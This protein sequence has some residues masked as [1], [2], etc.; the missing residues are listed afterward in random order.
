[1]NEK[2]PV[3]RPLITLDDLPKGWDKKLITMGKEGKF[4][5]HVRTYLNI[6][7]DTFYRL[8][9]DEPKFLET[10]NR[11]RELSQEWWVN[12]P[13]ESFSKG[14]SKNMNSQLYSLIMRNRF[15]GWNDSLTKIDIT[16][17]GEK[18]DK[19]KIEIEIIKK[20]LENDL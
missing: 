11:M 18:I 16:T 5:V 7:N 9:D 3:G 15:Q 19:Q 10:V 12:L 20:T 13:I 4:D 6:T 1:M 2:R 8:L 14:D 17:Q